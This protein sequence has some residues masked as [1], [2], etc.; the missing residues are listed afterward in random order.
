[1]KKIAVF[2]FALQVSVLAAAG[3]EVP[4]ECTLCVGA[5]SDAKAIPP[6]PLPLLLQVRQEDLASTGSWL[7]TLSSEQRGKLTVIITYAISHDADPLLDVEQHTKAIV[8][9]AR[10]HGSFD[11]IGVVAEGTDL[12]TAG[13]A[14]KRLSVTAQGQAAATRIVLPQTSLDALAKLYETGAQTSFDVVLS[15]APSLAHLS[16]W[17]TDTDP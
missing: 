6:S 15:A 17:L 9:W 3:A 14:I 2:V 12:A 5:V 10:L 1:M 16:K 11:A 13:Y 7:D 4:R 8:E